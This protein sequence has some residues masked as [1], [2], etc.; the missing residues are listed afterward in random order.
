MLG[1]ARALDLWGTSG[2]VELLAPFTWLSGTAVDNAGQRVSRSVSGFA[3]PAIRLSVN[4]Y[5]AP[6][7]TMQEFHGWKQDL[8]VGAA[9]TV[10]PPLGQ[11]DETRLV[12]IG[13]NRWWFKPSLGVSQS[14]GPWTLEAT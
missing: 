8:V 2:K 12:N 11:Y 6:A 9:L 4:L 5:G 10:S 14:L 3:D 1:Y 7:L 13:S